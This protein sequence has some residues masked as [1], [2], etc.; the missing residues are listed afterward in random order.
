MGGWLGA[1]CWVL[2]MG[3]AEGQGPDAAAARCWSQGGE[4]ARPPLLATSASALEMSA[5]RLSPSEVVALRPWS[6][7][8]DLVS[9][10]SIASTC[11]GAGAQ[12]ASCQACC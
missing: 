11:S 2:R 3:A 1:G 9:A 4:L 10:A 6:A 8:M 7:K 12:G 5:S